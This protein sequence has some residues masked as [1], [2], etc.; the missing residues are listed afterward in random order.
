MADLF[1]SLSAVKDTFK[2]H[3]VQLELE[4][5]NKL[6]GELLR[7]QAQLREQRATLE[8]SWADT[9]KSGVY[10]QCA[11]N[12][13]TTSTLCVSLHRTCAPGTRSSQMSFTPVPGKH[14]PW[15][16]Q[17]NMRSRPGWRPL[18]QRS[19]RSPP[20]TASLLSARRN[21]MLCSS[22]TPSSGTSVL[23]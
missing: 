1:L 18:P 13:L 12:T 23:C 14:G 10:M 11:A 15:V 7:K 8:T 22:E 6:I 21:A 19:S 20:V 9:H 16:Q 4:A 5:V 2:L 3:L 17:R